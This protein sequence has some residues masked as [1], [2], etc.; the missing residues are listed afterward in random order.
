[1]YWAYGIL[2]TIVVLSLFTKNWWCRYFC[3]L[4]GFF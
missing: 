3:P 4:G 1:M 2:G